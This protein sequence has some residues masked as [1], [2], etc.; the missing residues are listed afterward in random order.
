M[1]VE[2]KNVIEI[3]FLMRATKFKQQKLKKI[4]NAFEKTYYY[5]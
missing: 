5:V 4:S 3:N 1:E 2:I